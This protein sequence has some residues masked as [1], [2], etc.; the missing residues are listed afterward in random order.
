[1]KFLGRALKRLK[2]SYLPETSVVLNFI[3]ERK[4]NA[5]YV[6]FG[7]IIL[8]LLSAKNV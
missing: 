2:G 8:L 7:L 1:M 6:D 4:R 5:I 3:I